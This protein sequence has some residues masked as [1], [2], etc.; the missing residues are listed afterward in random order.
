[1]ILGLAPMDWFTDYAFRQITKEVFDRYWDKK[2]YEL[3]LWTEFMNANGYLINPVGVVKHLLANKEQAPLIAQIFGNEKETLVTSF[4]EIE[5][6][7]IEYFQWLELNLWCPAKTVIQN[8]WGSALLK[9]KKNT[10]DI[11]KAIKKQTILPLSIKTRTGITDDDR[12]QQKD[13]LI[14]A[15]TYCDTIT[16][17][18]RTVKQA[19]TGEADWEFI[20]DMK[21]NIGKKCK[22]FGNGWIKSYEEIEDKLWNL[23]GVLIG[24][25]AIGNPRIFTPH[26]PS[27]KELKETILRHLNLMVA[28]ELYF[29]QQAQKFTGILIMPTQK[30]LDKIISTLPQLSSPDTHLQ[31][32]VVAF[33]KHLFQYI[34]WID[35]SK[36]WKRNISMIKEYNELVKEIEKFF[37]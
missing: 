6:K 11:I 26:T 1:M 27:K 30:E 29:A 14:Q 23:D 2:K 8:G 25:A 21:K 16:I 24:Q 33:R 31:A 7:Y 17:H 12:L 15:S 13:F 3:M 32:I 35:G 5:K 28:S 9:D 36:E 19:Y 10:L 4:V 37:G 22:I 34:K 18:G 20:Y